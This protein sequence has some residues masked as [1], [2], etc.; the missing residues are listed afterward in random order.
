[1]LGGHVL[2]GVLARIEWQW[3]PA[4]RIKGYAVARTRGEWSAKGTVE[5]VDVFN[6]SRKPL[7]FVVPHAKGRWRWP[8][9]ELHL[10]RSVENGIEAKRFVARLGKPLPGDA[11]R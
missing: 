9:V 6:V 10:E 5:Y 1:M 4:A 7:F 3:Y 11:P 2:T 8:I